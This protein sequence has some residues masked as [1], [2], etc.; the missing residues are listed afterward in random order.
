MYSP[1]LHNAPLNIKKHT[2][3]SKKQQFHLMLLKNIN[4]SKD[5]RPSTRRPALLGTYIT[6]G[7]QFGSSGGHGN[8]SGCMKLSVP[9][10]TAQLTF[11]CTT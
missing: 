8:T 11:L 10:T 2:L 4:R 6:C 1:K 5:H 3:Y 7:A 9:P